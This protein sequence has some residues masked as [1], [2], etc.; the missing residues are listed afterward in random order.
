LNNNDSRQGFQV[1]PEGQKDVNQDTDMNQAD[2][3][4]LD[5][6]D[7]AFYSEITRSNEKTKDQEEDQ[8]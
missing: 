7:K 3:S 8:I 1:D 5:D 4:L 6:D 2:T